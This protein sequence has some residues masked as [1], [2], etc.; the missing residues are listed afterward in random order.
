MFI[1]VKQNNTIM[2]DNTDTE[3]AVNIPASYLE[4]DFDEVDIEVNNDNNSED[5]DIKFE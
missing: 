4:K 2:N 3:Y 1:F 5:T